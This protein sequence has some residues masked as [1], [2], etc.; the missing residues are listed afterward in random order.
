MTCA[1]SGKFLFPFT[2]NNKPHLIENG[3]A[4]IEKLRVNRGMFVTL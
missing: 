4:E 2:G 3:R 1:F